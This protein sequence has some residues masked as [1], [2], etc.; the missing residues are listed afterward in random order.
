MVLGPKAYKVYSFFGGVWG[1]AGIYRA[2]H[3]ELNVRG[4]C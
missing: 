1:L 4:L 2:S 3:V